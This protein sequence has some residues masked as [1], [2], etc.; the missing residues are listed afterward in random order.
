[1]MTTGFVIFFFAYLCRDALI[2]FKSLLGYCGDKAVTFPASQ[3][4]DFLRLGI[5]NPN[6]RN[7]L[8]LQA[9]KQTISNPSAYGQCRAFHVLC[10]CCDT[11]PPQPDFFYYVV[12]FLLSHSDSI[13]SGSDP[14]PIQQMAQYCLVRI[15]AMQNTDPDKM[16]LSVDV[17]AIEAYSA[18]L[19]TLAKIYSPDD[20]L[21]GELLVAPDVDVESLLTLLSSILNIHSS[22]QSLL[23][24][25][26]ATTKSNPLAPMILLPDKDFHIGDICQAPLLQK[27]GRPINY[28][29]KRKL[30]GENSVSQF[31]KVSDDE[32]ETLEQEQA[33]VDLTFSQLTKRVVEDT[34]RVNLLFVCDVP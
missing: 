26:V 12:N 1:M 22:H 16:P 9:I 29:V 13:I 17:E 23:G 28:Y 6:I 4:L 27:F 25:Y 8:Y 21:L 10:L 5:N 31:L 19:P 3:A 14:T 15:Q 7:E 34:I 18:R 33:L 2:A 20:L 11:F 32:P 24:L 30:L